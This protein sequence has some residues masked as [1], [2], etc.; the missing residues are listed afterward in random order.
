MTKEELV[1]AL[2]DTFNYAPEW[3]YEKFVRDRIGY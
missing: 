2:L 3:V 1:E